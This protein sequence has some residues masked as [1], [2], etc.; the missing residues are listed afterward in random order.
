MW[1]RSILGGKTLGLCRP[2]S[3]IANKFKPTLQVPD[4][5]ATKSRFLCTIS[6]LVWK[7]QSNINCLSRR[8]HSNANKKVGIVGAPMSKGQ[9]LEGVDMGPKAIRSGGLITALE[10]LGVDVKDYGDIPFDAKPDVLP[11][12][13]ARNAQ[14]VGAAL[15]KVVDK[16]KSVLQEGRVCLTLGGDHSLGIAT[17]VAHS[18]VHHDMCLLWV[19]AHADINTA[20]TTH[21][22]NLHGMP[23]S[24]IIREMSK[25]CPQVPGLDW[26]KPCLNAGNL[27]YI[28]LRDVEPSEKSFLLELGIPHFGMQEID[29]MGIHSV[30]TKALELINPKGNR[31]LHVSFDIDSVDKSLAPSTGTPVDGG[32]T[33]REALCIAEVV[34]S[35]GLLHGLDM[36]EVNPSLGSEEDAHKTVAAAIKIISAFFGN[37][38]DGNPL[39]EH[40]CP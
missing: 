23:C 6:P 38:R 24:F 7:I 21:S 18:Q 35:S 36:V 1:S 14:F 16:V 17:V 13:Q 8:F 10:E 2:A 30:L 22:G 19:D 11:N 31:P 28:G 3:V 39:P 33:L 12:P 4:S 26:I 9:G 29:K 40:K 27:A 37:Q 25:F 34:A 32:L 5:L 20:I 15:Q